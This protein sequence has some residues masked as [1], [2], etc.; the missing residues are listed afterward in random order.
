MTNKLKRILVA[1]DED[2]L[3]DMLTLILKD[4][5][6]H[7]DSASNGKEAWQ[8]LNDKHY[9]LLASDLF[10]PEMNGFELIEKCKQ[11][12]PAIKLLLFSG[13]G[14]ELDAEPGSKIIKFQGETTTVDL[15]LKKPYDL[16]DLLNNIE[17]LLSE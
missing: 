3:R 17:N 11:E 2:M 7:V 10:M 12:F 14:K 8:Q 13:G 1:E 5:G 6:Y 16:M 4:E 9:D 15:F